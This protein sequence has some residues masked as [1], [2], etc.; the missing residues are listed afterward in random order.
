MSLD[1]QL[2]PLTDDFLVCAV[3]TRTDVDKVEHSPSPSEAS[4]EFLKDLNVFNCSGSYQHFSKPT[5][6]CVD[7]A[8]HT[9]AERNVFHLV[10]DPVAH[11]V[12]K[13]RCSTATTR[14]SAADI[15]FTELSTSATHNLLIGA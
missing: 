8:D 12:I 5:H 1:L 15:L 6:V 9:G 11:G 14:F 13:L 2:S 3:F 10:L 4:H 7:S